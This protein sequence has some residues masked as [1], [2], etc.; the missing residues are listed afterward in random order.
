MV[1]CDILKAV[2]IKNLEFGTF[3]YAY[4]FVMWTSHKRAKITKQSTKKNLRR[5]K[6]SLHV[7]GRCN[8]KNKDIV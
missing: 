6:L 8:Y 7:Y 3:I 5:K 1:S 2:N 4:A